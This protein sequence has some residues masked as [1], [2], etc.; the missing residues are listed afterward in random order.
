MHRSHTEREREIQSL[1]DVFDGLQRRMRNLED[2][3]DNQTNTDKRMREY[4][5]EL[6]ELRIQLAENR[7]KLEMMQAKHSNSFAV[8]ACLFF[9][10][11]L[12]YGLYVLVNGV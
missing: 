8:A 1:N 2:N 11:F 5:D 10:C 9:I 12:V 4:W 6:S 7:Q 3:M